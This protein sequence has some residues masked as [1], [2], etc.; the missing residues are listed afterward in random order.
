MI[1]KFLNLMSF[2]EAEVLL[3]D[4]MSDRQETE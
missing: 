1:V 4:Q 3:N 2:F